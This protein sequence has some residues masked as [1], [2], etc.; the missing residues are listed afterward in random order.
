MGLVSLVI[1]QW[2]TQSYYRGG[3]LLAKPT[4]Q[5]VN[6]DKSEDGVIPDVAGGPVHAQIHWLVEEHAED[7]SR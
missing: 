3:S 5:V 7:K 6:G 4:F 2:S 1:D